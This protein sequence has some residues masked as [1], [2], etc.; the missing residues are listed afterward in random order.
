MEYLDKSMKRSGRKS[1]LRSNT[2]QKKAQTKN[3]RKKNSHPEDMEDSSNAADCNNCTDT[4]D[5]P[6]YSDSGGNAIKISDKSVSDVCK[7]VRFF[8]VEPACVER[9]I[10]VTMTGLCVHPSEF[11]Q[12]LT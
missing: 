4:M 5:E 7:F 11:V 10:V 9:D 12:T 8:V 6:F 3:G 2:R 1:S